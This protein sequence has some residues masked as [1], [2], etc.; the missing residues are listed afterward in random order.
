MEVIL[1]GKIK[2][3]EIAKK[4]GLASK[5]V[6]EVAGNLKIEVKSHMSGVEEAD[7]KRIE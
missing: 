1:L 6:L 2:I 3:Y 4:L 7:A 5:E